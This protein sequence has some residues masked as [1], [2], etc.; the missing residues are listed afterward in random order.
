MSPPELTI[1]GG[2]AFGGD[3]NPEQWPRQT[4]DEDLRLMR[5]AGVTMVT[6]GV[7]AW[8]QVE[9]R[10]GEFVFDDLDE[11]LDRLHRG[12]IAV[13]LATA[14]ASR[15]PWLS[16]RYPEILPVD[17]DGHRYWPGSRQTFCPSSPIVRRHQLMLVD[18]L[19]T[20]Y[21]DHPALALW[22]VGNE[23]GCHN[24]HCY[25]DVSAEAFRAWL[26]A[27]YGDIVALNAAWGTA[28]W[29]QRYS[30][31][32][33]VLPPRRT[34]TFGNPTQE[35]DFWRFSSDEIVASL[36][37]ERDVL[38]ARTPGIP[39]TTNLLQDLKH[40]D[41]F[42]LG[43]ACDLVSIDHYLLAKIPDSHVDL[44][45]AADFARGAARGAPWLLMEHSTSAVNW[46][47]VNG[48][49]MPGE[50]R[51]NSLAHV[52]RG[53]DGALF[54]QWRASASG[55]EKFHS[56]IVPHAGT[57]SRVW[58]ESVELGRD[59]EALD[60][61]RG[62]RVD[63]P[64]ALVVDWHAWWASELSAHPSSELKYLD[65]LRDVHSAFWRL[66]V[67]AD[68][69]HPTDDLSRYSLVVVPTLYVVDDPTITAIDHYVHKGGRILVSYFSGITDVNDRVRLGGYPGA[70]A[71]LLGVRMEEFCPLPIGGTTQ[72]SDGAIGTLWTERGR[73][74]TASVLASFV[75]GPAAG[76]PAVTRVDAGFGAAWYVATRLEPG[77]WERFLDSI[78]QECRIAPTA[79]GAPAGLEALRRRNRSGASWL[80][81][82]N[83][84]PEPAT[85]PADGCDLLT[86][87]EVDGEITVPPGGVA[88]I[89]ESQPRS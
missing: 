32:S 9:P 39:V 44:A 16:T 38:H 42:A 51:R 21:A 86:G 26:M 83:H 84:R 25:C 10:E 69:V 19:A 59:L 67:T 36:V 82:L 37:A 55:A 29:S 20:R 63:A 88:V 41:G 60:E 66:G 11:V 1:P 14:T 34:S 3:Y 15:P 50:L 58:R 24:A 85:V 35:L 2:L 75:D 43:R 70:F 87:V 8:A 76:S 80:F 12:G 46:Q 56:A 73:V 31:W 4:W 61:I 81:L 6:V 49:K 47:G 62:S 77:G 53:S 18:R 45:L 40:V 74:T 89:R 23:L 27:R 68:V 30:D 17:R 65:V 72:L 64:V 13:D 7:F 22:H 5:E 54:F 52:A 78:L 57:D 79:P 48:A 28:F 33:E 71:D